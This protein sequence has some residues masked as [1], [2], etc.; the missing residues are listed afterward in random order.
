MAFDFD[1]QWDRRHTSSLK[2]THCNPDTIPM[3]VADMDFQSDPGIIKALHQRVSH[4][5][6]GYT[7]PDI[8]LE[9]SVVD[10]CEQA[11]HWHIDPQWLVWLP[12]VVSGVHLAIRSATPE[13]GIVM[14]PAPVY[15]PFLEASALSKRVQQLI[16]WHIRNNR[17]VLDMAAMADHGPDSHMLLLCNPHN[18]NGRM[19]TCSELEQ[20]DAICQN[21]NLIVCSDEI[22]CDLVLDKHR[23]HIPYATVSD[24]ALNHSITLMS[25]SKTFNIAGLGCAFA[26]IPNPELRTRFSTVRKG[27]VPGINSNLL[28]YTAAKA[29][30]QQGKNWLEEALAY[31][32]N[33]H[34]LLLD[35]MNSLPGLHMLPLEATYLAWIDCSG[36]PVDDPCQ[37]FEQAG[38]GVSCGEPFG[39]RRFVRLNFGCSRSLLEEAIE[40]IQHAVNAL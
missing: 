29:A 32:R 3:W 36:L 24:Y 16:P 12:G 19:L 18:P 25:P 17:W 30:Y 9:N 6:F 7:S 39:N 8:E 35:S 40:M 26:I 31:L 34:N 22:H 38:V 5:I 20:I 21:N 14:I 10:W 1:A 23:Q 33:N 2:W 13:K 37:F 4:G 28:G 11:Y 27:I 15:P